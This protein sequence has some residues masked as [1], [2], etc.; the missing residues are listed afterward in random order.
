ME[1]YSYKPCRI[2]VQGVCFGHQLVGTAFGGKVGRAGFFEC[3]AREVT[4]H[5][6]AKAA[7]GAPWAELLPD[8]LVINECH[9][10]QV[11]GGWV[12]V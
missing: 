2:S 1:G 10:D 8:T 6:E 5:S 12:E 9:Q 3:G 4:V 11:K 7:V